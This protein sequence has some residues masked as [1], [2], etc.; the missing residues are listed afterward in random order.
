M[1]RAEK[2]SGWANDDESKGLLM[3]KLTGCFLAML[4]L[5]CTASLPELA[6]GALPPAIY[7]LGALRPEINGI[8][9]MSRGYAVNANGQVAGY[10]DTSDGSVR[11]F[12]YSGTPGAE[13]MMADLGT[14]DYRSCANGLHGSGPVVGAS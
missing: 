1:Q 10:S 12:L 2:R 8:M 3:R 14:L 11:A 5:V 13:G 7:D 6:G 4:A 9:P